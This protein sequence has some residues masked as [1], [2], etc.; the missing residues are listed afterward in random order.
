MPISAPYGL[1]YLQD[2]PPEW[3]AVQQAAATLND[4]CLSI[5]NLVGAS[6]DEPTP[7][8]TYA[9]DCDVGGEIA[10]LMYGRAC[11]LFLFAIDH[12]KTVTTSLR[13]RANTFA[14]FTCA[15]AV[16]E[17]CSTASWILD[18]EGEIDSDNRFRRFFDFRLS[19][20]VS[21]RRQLNENSGIPTTLGILPEEAEELYQKTMKEVVAQANVLGIKPTKMQGKPKHPVFD[22][23]PGRSK[24]TLAD[25][26]FEHG[27][28]RY[29]T[30]SAVAHGAPWATESHWLIKADVEN[31]GSFLYQPKKAYHMIVSIMTWLQVASRRIFTYSGCNLFELDR[32]LKS[33][34]EQAIRLAKDVGYELIGTNSD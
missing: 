10:K 15:R 26:Y 27:A 7:G 34:R 24:T 12:A 33:Y 18:S 19:D 20:P 13:F 8:S 28:L 9:D 6:S 32:N 4:M 23:D 17:S 30:Y 14:S 25:R 11:D 1:T 16:L 22:V 21:I 2:V 3:I 5:G 29:Q 31:P